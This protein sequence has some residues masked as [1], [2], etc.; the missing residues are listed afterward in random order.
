MPEAATGTDAGGAQ[1]RGIDG[2]EHSSTLAALWPCTTRDNQGERTAGYETSSDVIMT[3][4]PTATRARTSHVPTREHLAIAVVVR[5]DGPTHASSH[6]DNRGVSAPREAA[7]TGFVG[8]GGGSLTP[9][10]LLLTR[11]EPWIGRQTTRPGHRPE[12]LAQVARHLLLQRFRPSASTNAA[13]AA[14]AFARRRP[15]TAE[16]QVCVASL[17]SFLASAVYSS[18]H[19]RTGKEDTRGALAKCLRTLW[20]ERCAAGFARCLKSSETLT[21]SR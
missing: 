11:D 18:G 4:P 17:A 19:R 21:T 5:S 1:R 3:R 15:H 12:S 13:P 2:A 20:C 10:L 6:T 14:P 16:S 8:Q 9:R 7:Q